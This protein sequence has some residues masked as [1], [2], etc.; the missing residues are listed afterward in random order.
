MLRIS[1]HNGSVQVA[2]TQQEEEKLGIGNLQWS[3]RATVT[4][5]TTDYRR[6]ALHIGVLPVAKT[7]IQQTIDAWKLG[8]QQDDNLVPTLATVVSEKG[9]GQEEWKDR[10]S[11]ILKN[12]PLEKEGEKVGLGVLPILDATPE[13]NLVPS[14]TDLAQ[15]MSDII[16]TFKGRCS[17]KRIEKQRLSVFFTEGD[18]EAQKPTM[19]KLKECVTKCTNNWPNLLPQD[20]APQKRGETRII[21]VEIRKDK[22]SGEGRFL[23]RSVSELGLSQEMQELVLNMANCSL[24]RATWRS[25]STAERAAERCQRELNVALNMPWGVREVVVFTAWCIRKQYAS[26]TIKQYSSGIKNAHKREGMSVEAWDSHIVKAVVKGKENSE[27][28]RKQK[29]AMTPG[30]LLEIK[31]YIIKSDLSYVDKCAV[32]AVCTLMYSGSLRGGEA[33]GDQEDNFDSRNILMEEDVR[34]KALRLVDGRRVKMVCCKIR[35]P[36]ELP[37]TKEVE[38]EMFQTRNKYCPVQAVEKLKQARRGNVKRPFACRESGRIITKAFLNN[39]IKKALKDLVDYEEWTVSSHSF[40]AGVATGMARAGYGDEEI[41]RQG[42]WRSD[43]FLQYIRL[44]RS[45]R[46]EQQQKLAEELAQIAEDENMELSR[47]GQRRNGA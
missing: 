9:P 27:T 5:S 12:L 28:P 14:R 40:R 29:I 39:F 8:V 23:A 38:I 7:R 36:K 46:L 47:A 44:G 21:P 30:L 6:T 11:I 4:P 19:D 17:W 42:R 18:E 41:K 1:T 33:M 2:L 35:N 25:Y 16:A 20:K 13:D 31:R 32:W 37:G 34:I 10:W 3:L 45:Q 43:A 22:Y 26:S 24:S 15:E